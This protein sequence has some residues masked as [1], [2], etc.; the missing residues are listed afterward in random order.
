M[1]RGAPTRLLTKV[2]RLAGESAPASPQALRRTFG[3]AGLTAG[4]RC[5]TCVAAYLT[6]MAIG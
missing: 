5:G 3:T 6:G 2:V 1:K 4:R